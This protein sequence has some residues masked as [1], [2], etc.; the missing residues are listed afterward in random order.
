MCGIVGY[1]GHR[2]ALPVV[3]DGLS[4][5]SYRGYDSAGI[6]VMDHQNRIQVRKSRGKL[7]ELEKIVARDS[8]TGTIGIGHTRWATHGEPSDRNAHP[9]TDMSGSIAVVHNGI[10]ENYEELKMYLKKQGI[11]M[12]TQTDTEVIAHLIHLMYQG[13]M[14]KTLVELI[15]VLE[16]SYALGILCEQEPEKLYCVRNE[17]PLIIGFCNGAGYIAS[18]IPALLN[19]TRD[20]VFL[21]DREIAILTDNGIQIFDAHGQHVAQNFY[22]VNWEMSDAEK[23]GYRHFMLK[24]IHEQPEALERTINRYCRETNR[25]LPFTDEEVLGFRKLTIVACGT[26]YH[27][28]VYAKYVIESLAG[29]P[30]EAEVASEY[31]YRNPVVADNELV[32]AVS[33]SGETADTLAAVRLAKQKGA[34]VLA[35]CNVADSSVVREVGEKNTLYTHAGPEIAVASTKAYLTQTVI[36]LLMAVSMAETRKTI[37]PQRLLSLT[38]SLR[39]IKELTENVL[40]TEEQVQ[41]L[42]NQFFMKKHVFFAGRGLDYALSMEAALKLKEVSYIFSEAYAAGE[43]KHGPLALM[44]EGCL[45]M[46]SVTQ[47]ELLEKSLSNLQE[48]TARGAYVVAVTSNLLA[49]RVAAHVNQAIRIPDC[50]PLVAPLLAAIPM[51]LFAYYMALERGCDVDQPRNLAK[52]VTVE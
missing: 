15:R 47:P 32:I 39:E 31:R 3:M 49:D 41:R 10:I 2:Q 12:S 42:A 21:Q 9:H 24:E 50:D 26:A 44:Q 37:D 27:A 51:Q 4:R 19:H 52:S 28:G 23:D 35:V 43:L 33:Q 30:V 1:V 17:S 45:V 48:I 18:D 46:A 20:V 25:W 34:R 14:V 29:I 22:H 13:D 6:A 11:N 36:L 16:G 8:V 5:L 38:Q 40:R 7:A